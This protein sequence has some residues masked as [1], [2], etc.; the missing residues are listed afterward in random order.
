MA[1]CIH[2]PVETEND[3]YD[4]PI[5]LLHETLVHAADK[6]GKK[7][8]MITAGVEYSYEKMLSDTE[9]VA[10]LFL[11]KGLRRGDRVIIFM[12]NSYVSVISLYAALMAGGVFTVIN[13]QTKRDKF[14]YILSDSGARIVV[15]ERRLIPI[16]IDTKRKGKDEI[17]ILYSTEGVGNTGVEKEYTHVQEIFGALYDTGPMTQLKKTIPIDLAA[18]IY[19][20]GS[21][22]NPKGV[23]MSHQAMLFAARSISY[24]LRIDCSHTII[25]VLPL[26]FDYGLYQ[27]LMSVVCCATV[28]V[29]QSFAYPA[30][31]VKKIKECSVTVFPGVPTVY[32]TLIAMHRRNRIEITGVTRLTNTAASLPPDYTEELHQIFPNALLFR[33]YGL[34]ECKRVCYL[35]PELADNKPSS[36]GKAIPGTET[37]ILDQENKECEPG[38]PGILYVRGPHVMM[39]YW[40]APELSARMLHIGPFPGERVLCTHDWFR[41]DEDGDLYFLGRTDDIIKSRGEKVSPVEVEHAL[42]ALKGVREAAVIGVPDELLGQAVKAFVVLDN[43]SITE[44]DILKHCSEHLENYMVPKYIVVLS[45]LPK[46]DTGKITK[47]NLS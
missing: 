42:V 11:D 19:T 28:V 33:M 40:N 39:G 38:E 3:M 13:P 25:N 14:A 34:T 4:K 30:E 10:A 2:N 44:Q 5:W 20:S 8:A 31:I 21:T 29:E 24:Y 47:K 46:T 37:W 15:T 6:Y 23:M 36:V 35:E 45:S 41:K 27:V 17:T 1:G 22:G 26:A 43:S 7:V 9:R 32:T 12:E 16:V 18:L